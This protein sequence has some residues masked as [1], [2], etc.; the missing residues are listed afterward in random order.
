V[1]LR[2]VRHTLVGL[3][4]VAAT[5]LAGAHGEIY[6]APGCSTATTIASASIY[7]HST[8]DGS[9][10]LIENTCNGHVW[11]TTYD[12]WSFSGYTATVNHYG[13][14]SYAS[15]AFCVVPTCMVNTPESDHVPGSWYQAYGTQNGHSAWTAWVYVTS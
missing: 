3:I 7:D 9:V 14:P 10:Y 2:I 8:Y 6:A 11:A 13:Y 15:N 4:M 12:I 5:G 1:K